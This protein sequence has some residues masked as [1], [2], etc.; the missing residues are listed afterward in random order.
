M[1]SCT[2]AKGASASVPPPMPIVSRHKAASS[3]DVI[4]DSRNERTMQICAWQMFKACL[5]SVS[6]SGSAAST[7]E[8]LF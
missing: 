3:V 8:A 7:R 5:N 1:R 6:Y 2:A 4:F